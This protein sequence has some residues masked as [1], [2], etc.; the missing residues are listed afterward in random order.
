MITPTKAVLPD[1]GMTAFRNDMLA[2][3]N[4]HAGELDSSAM[5]AIAAYT[6]GQI[7]AMQD[8][9]TMTPATAMDL[10]S[11]NIEAGNADAIAELVTKTAG[12]A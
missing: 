8:Q 9:R 6:V 11:R 3:L 5:L 12:R 1:E 7:I 4:K 2:T 10:V